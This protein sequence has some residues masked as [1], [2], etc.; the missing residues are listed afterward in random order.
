MPNMD[1]NYLNVYKAFVYLV[2][3]ILF[4]ERLSEIIRYG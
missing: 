1:L 4:Q 2:I 3:S